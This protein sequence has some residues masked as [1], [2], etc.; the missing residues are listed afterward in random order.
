MSTREQAIAIID[1]M[2]EE[3][4]Q[5]FVS[6]FSN[7]NSQSIPTEAPDDWDRAMIEDSKEDND[8]RMPLDDFV[9]ELGFSPDDLRI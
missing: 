9:R 6:T 5:E 2:S 1:L 3:Q 4:L 8:E 7:L